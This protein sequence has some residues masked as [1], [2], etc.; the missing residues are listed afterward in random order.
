MIEHACLHQRRG[1]DCGQVTASSLD[2]QFLAIAM[3]S[4]LVYIYILKTETINHPK[5]TTENKQ[6]WIHLL[7]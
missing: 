7:I 6:T 5:T 2:G 4:Q 3:L 1:S